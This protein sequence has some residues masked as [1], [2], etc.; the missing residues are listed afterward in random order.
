MLDEDARG[1]YWYFEPGIDS[2]KRAVQELRSIVLKHGAG[3][4]SAAKAA[5]AGLNEAGAQGQ[6]SK[7][8][9]EIDPDHKKWC[10]SALMVEEET[11]AHNGCPLPPPPQVDLT[12]SKPPHS[13]TLT[14]N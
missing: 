3:C 1:E 6:Q 11:G 10:P 4:S 14:L 9:R 8:A 2:N 13:L 7:C 12:M 5:A